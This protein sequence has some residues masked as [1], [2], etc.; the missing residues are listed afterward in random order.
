M[1]L[2]G[3]A[4][5]ALLLSAAASACHRAPPTPGPVASAS[6]SPSSSAASLELATDANFPPPVPVALGPSPPG[7]ASTERAERLRELLRGRLPMAQLPL[8]ATDE[9]VAFSPNQYRL[10]TTELDT[11]GGLSALQD[12]LVATVQPAVLVSGKL[13]RASLERTSSMRGSFRSC[14][15]RAREEKPTLAGKVSLLVVVAQDGSVSSVWTESAPPDSSMLVGC[16][17]ARVLAQL[18]SSPIG[19]AQ[20][21]LRLQITFTAEPA[22]AP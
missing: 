21:K 22:P 18:F 4:L 2:V 13:D 11:S 17:K 15:R 14:Y 10:L 9:G 19:R 12:K 1:K 5:G 8:V 7:A 3:T 20:A 6:A 16:V